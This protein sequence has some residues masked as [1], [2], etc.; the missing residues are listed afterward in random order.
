MRRCS[1]A[2]VTER[3]I[4]SEDEKYELRKKTNKKGK[5]QK[6]DKGRRIYGNERKRKKGS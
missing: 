6:G 4:T 3:E 5:M 2:G 1:N